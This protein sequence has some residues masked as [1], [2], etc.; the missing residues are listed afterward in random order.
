MSDALGTLLRVENVRGGWSWGPTNSS[1]N[2]DVRE[3][4]VNAPDDAVVRHRHDRI[5]GDALI[6]RTDPNVRQAVVL[7]ERV[8]RCPEE[9]LDK[10]TRASVRAWSLALLLDKGVE[11][12]LAT[13]R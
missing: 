8:N 1:R 3:V 6:V 9:E 4:V 5:H 7:T 13:A 12:A 11:A 10:S 2:I